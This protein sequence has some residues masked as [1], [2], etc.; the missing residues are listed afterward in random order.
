M[1]KQTPVLPAARLALPCATSGQ[2]WSFTSQVSA[3]RRASLDSLA[4]LILIAYNT[5]TLQL[6]RWEHPRPSAVPGIAVYRNTQH[7]SSV[8]QPELLTER[9]SLAAGEPHAPSVPK[10][11][12][13]PARTAEPS[14]SSK[15][16]RKVLPQRQAARHNLYRRNCSGTR[17][18]EGKKSRV[19]L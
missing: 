16:S 18:S 1:P 4:G 2:P 12:P 10:A 5:P 7:G 3:G 19:H 8:S 15:G 9:P 11:R 13:K 17:E 6:C 14:S